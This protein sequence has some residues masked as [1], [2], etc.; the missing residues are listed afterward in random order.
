MCW[1][2]SK[3]RRNWPSSWEVLCWG[4]WGSWWSTQRGRRRPPSTA[5]TWSC[6]SLWACSAP[7]APPFCR[8]FLYKGDT[9]ILNFREYPGNIDEVEGWELLVAPELR[10]RCKISGFCQFPRLAAPPRP[11][12]GR[13]WWWGQQRCW[14]RRRGRRWRRRCRR[15]T[16]RCGKELL[17]RHP[18]KWLPWS[19]ATPWRKIIRNQSVENKNPERSESS[20]LRMILTYAGHPSVVWTANKVS[21]AAATLS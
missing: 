5:C 3:R 13:W 12:L 18:Q 7:R 1:I 21:I 4:R 8:D 11:A 9:K 20:E 14:R 19:F 6:P 2:L 15:W 16:S 17:V 10:S